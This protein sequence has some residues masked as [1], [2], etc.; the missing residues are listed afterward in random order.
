[1]WECRV[2]L[3]E[4]LW[5]TEL[6]DM[7]CM[8][9]SLT[10]IQKKCSNPK[11]KFEKHTNSWQNQPRGSWNNNNKH[12]HPIMFLFWKV[13]AARLLLK[14]IC[15]LSLLCPFR[16]YIFWKRSIYQ[17]NTHVH[18]WL[19][20]AEHVYM[21]AEISFL[22]YL[23]VDRMMDHLFALAEGHF[24]PFWCDASMGYSLWLRTCF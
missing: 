5:S 14:N 7:S 11:I 18:F 1:M 8:T 15:V 17:M 3:Y 16:T 9:E 12:F 6:T 13:V 19:M 20:C 4:Q 10:V 24:K 2:Y 23:T 22:S 21:F